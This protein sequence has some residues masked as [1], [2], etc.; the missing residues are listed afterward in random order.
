MSYRFRESLP[1]L[2][3][4]AATKC[5]PLLIRHFVDGLEFRF[6]FPL[7]PDCSVC[8]AQAN[9]WE[10]KQASIQN[11]PVLFRRMIV[12]DWLHGNK[13][14]KKAY[15]RLDRNQ[16]LLSTSWP[17]GSAI[18]CSLAIST[19]SDIGSITVTRLTNKQLCAKPTFG[20]LT[21]ARKG[22]TSLPA[23]RRARDLELKTVPKIRIHIFRG[24]LIVC[25]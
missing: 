24:I 20:V 5:P 17:W 10:S 19:S 9:L 8:A 2:Q 14:K 6:F 23:R 16:C 15:R 3:S 21:P 7:I 13:K 18:N 4:E 12:A 11:L 25:L 22:L 1:I